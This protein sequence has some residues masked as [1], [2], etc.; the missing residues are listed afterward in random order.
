MKENT[1]YNPNVKHPPEDFGFASLV[2]LPPPSML[3]RF[4]HLWPPKSN[5]Y[6]Y[7]KSCTLLFSRSATATAPLVITVTPSGLLNWFCCSP[8]APNIE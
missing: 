7:Q 2:S 3:E 6:R 8:H 1:G 4:S 5:T